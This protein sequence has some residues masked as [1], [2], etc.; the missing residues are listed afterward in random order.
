MAMFEPNFWGKMLGYENSEAKN[1]LLGE[2]AWLGKWWG[3]KP[4]FWEKN[5]WLGKWWGP[6]PNFWRKKC[7]VKKMAR[8]KT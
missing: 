4:N 8:F 2:N 6:K 7:L 1:L 3:P 5:A